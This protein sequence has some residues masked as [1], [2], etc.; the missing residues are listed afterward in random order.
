[1]V[2]IGKLFE[3]LGFPAM[4]SP[5]RFYD[6]DT[7][8]AIEIKTSPFYTKLIVGDK[9]FFFNRESGKYDGFGAMYP[10]LPNADYTADCIPEST[11]SPAPCD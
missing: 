2:L 4:V 11:E 6:S 1:M 9:E 3:W 5:F 8:Q 7:G 10:D